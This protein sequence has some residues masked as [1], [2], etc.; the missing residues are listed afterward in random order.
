M[1]PKS[2]MKAMPYQITIRW[3]EE[4]QAYQAAVPALRGCLAYGDSP[5]EAVDEVNTAAE[6]WLEAARR[7]CK[8][9]PR[10]DSTL[11]R[12]TALAPILNMSALAREAS[13]SA[14]T[15][16]SKM[17]RGTPL[18]EAEQ[19]AVERVLASHGLS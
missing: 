3:S 12:L 5:G 13:I 9:I 15:I 19:G 7:H 14:Q 17:K 11:E 18:T 6:L 1:K 8:P 2:T 16:A 4:D 10:P